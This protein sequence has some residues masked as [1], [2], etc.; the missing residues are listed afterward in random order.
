MADCKQ[1]IDQNAVLNAWFLK[2]PKIKM[3]DNCK[4]LSVYQHDFKEMGKDNAVFM[5]EEYTPCDT[6]ARF[7]TLFVG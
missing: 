6:Q 7:I 1:T 5:N 3:M 2:K 4:K